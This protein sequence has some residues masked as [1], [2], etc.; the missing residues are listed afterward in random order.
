MRA[1]DMPISV[2]N[3]QQSQA[4][5]QRNANQPAH[6]QSACPCADENQGECDNAFCDQC[7]RVHDVYLSIYRL[8]LKVALQVINPHHRDKLH[9]AWRKYP[10]ALDFER[11]IEQKRGYTWAYERTR[12][13]EHTSELQSRIH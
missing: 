7:F 4:V 9:P 6:A 8:G 5:S 13:E 10:A 2:G 3:N 1:G 11:P 12:S